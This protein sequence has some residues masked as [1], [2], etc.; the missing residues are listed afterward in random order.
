[1]DGMVTSLAA[2]TG[3]SPAQ[4]ILCQID[5][6]SKSSLQHKDVIQPGY[7]EQGT[8]FADSQSDER[9]RQPL[10]PQGFH[11]GA[12]AHISVSCR[13]LTDSKHSS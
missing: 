7:H 9:E 5:A 6:L 11:T 4:A 8:D 1:M 12:I 10:K 13:Y 3:Q 2:Q